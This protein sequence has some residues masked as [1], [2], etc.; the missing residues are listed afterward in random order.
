MLKFSYLLLLFCKYL[1]II[2]VNLKGKAIELE[3]HHC[4][5]N[6]EDGNFERIMGTAFRVV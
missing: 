4:N 1:L 2:K 6:G 3:L 5:T